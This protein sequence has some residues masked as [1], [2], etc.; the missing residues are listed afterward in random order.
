MVQYLR[1]NLQKPA[2]RVSGH[3]KVLHLGPYYLAHKVWLKELAWDKRSGLFCQSVG[4]EEK[5][6]SITLTFFFVTEAQITK[7]ECMSS[8]KHCNLA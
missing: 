2:L 5:I 6:G 8:A 3:C 4:D 1:V 7:P